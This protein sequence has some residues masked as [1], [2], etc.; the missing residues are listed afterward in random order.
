MKKRAVRFAIAVALMPVL[1]PARSV[2]QTGATAM[3]GTSGATAPT[4]AARSNEESA[5]QL[6]SFV[7]QLSESQRDQLHEAFD[8]GLKDAAPIE[9]QMER[10]KQAFNSAVLTG[11]SAEEIK[12]LAE[13]QGALTSQI[14][15]LQ[16]RTFENMLKIL[17]EHQ[18]TQVDDF[19]F[20]NIRLFLPACP[21]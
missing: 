21:E 14:L 10:D 13:H 19:V 2:V 15:L 16:A 8:Q 18:K 1:C 4:A 9:S 12:R 11:K 3:Q 20:K 6:I 17:N 7:L 5:L